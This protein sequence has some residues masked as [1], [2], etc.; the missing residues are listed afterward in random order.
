[1]GVVEDGSGRSRHRGMRGNPGAREMV[2]AQ[3]P[4][5]PWTS[6]ECTAVRNGSLHHGSRSTSVLLGGDGRPAVRRPG[7]RRF[8][9][10]SPD[11]LRMFEP[12][13]AA[14]R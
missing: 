11:H 3:P 4:S 13:D 5:G 7:F 1:M 6:F 2:C 10:C 12:A 14:T 8:G 9:G